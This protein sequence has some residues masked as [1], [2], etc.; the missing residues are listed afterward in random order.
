MGTLRRECL[1]HLLIYGDDTSGRSWPST[2]STTTLTGRTRRGNKTAAAR[3][4]RIDLTARIKRRRAV[5]A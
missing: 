4:R 1:D 2:H 5:Q 3:A